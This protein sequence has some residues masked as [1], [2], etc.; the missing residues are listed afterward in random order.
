MNA[1]KYYTVL[2]AYLVTISI[3]TVLYKDTDTDTLPV[4]K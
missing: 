1:T 3:I 2:Y 4:W